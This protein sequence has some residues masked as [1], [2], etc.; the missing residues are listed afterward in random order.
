MTYNIKD[1]VVGEVGLVGAD[2]VLAPFDS[3][4]LRIYSRR[5]G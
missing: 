5:F 2:C 3:L 4:W 1:I